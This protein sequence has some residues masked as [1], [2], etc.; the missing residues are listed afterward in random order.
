MRVNK[1]DSYTDLELALMVL[2]DYLGT[3]NVRKNKLGSRYKDVQSLV[4]YIL[5]N[6]EI[7]E[8]TGNTTIEDLNKVLLQ[9]EPS[10]NDY[11]DYVDEIIDKV[12]E[13][14]RWIT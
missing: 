13:G 5:L 3:G 2:L 1:I 12:K 14:T 11:V 9:M 8:G 7:P 4:N 6:N 10:H